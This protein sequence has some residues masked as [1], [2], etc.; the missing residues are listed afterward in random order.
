[1]H[2]S[3]CPQCQRY[4]A[5]ITE[6]TTA[7]EQ[8][9]RLN[10]QMKRV[11]DE[12][13]AKCAQKDIDLARKEG[14]MNAKLA[15]SV[16]DVERLTAEL[17]L[18]RGETGVLGSMNQSVQVVVSK[19]ASLEAHMMRLADDVRGLRPNDEQPP[20]A[21]A[22]FANSRLRSPG[23]RSLLVSIHNNKPAPPPPMAQSPTPDSP[24]TSERPRRLSID[25]DSSGSSSSSGG[26]VSSMTTCPPVVHIKKP[27]VSRTTSI[28]P[29]ETPGCSSQRLVGFKHCIDHNNSNSQQPTEQDRRG[30]SDGKSIGAERR[31]R[32]PAASRRTSLPIRRA[33]SSTLPKAHVPNDPD[34]MEY[35]EFDDLKDIVDPSSALT[36]AMTN[37]VRGGDYWREEFAALDDIRVLVKFHPDLILPELVPITNKMIEQLGNLRSSIVINCIMAFK[38]LLSCLGSAMD[39]CTKLVPVAIRKAVDKNNQFIVAEG[40]ALVDEI[41]RAMSG[42]KVCKEALPL[43]GDK[44]KN[45]RALAS[46]VIFMALDKFDANDVNDPAFNAEL[47]RAIA[48]GLTDSLTECRTDSK[49][50]LIVLR[51]KLEK[52]NPRVQAEWMKLVKNLEP[53]YALPVQQCLAS[54]PVDFDQ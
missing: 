24:N 34:K 10:A 38:A 27:L 48:P 33:A 6:L 26:T 15:Y 2:K 19:M 53:K 47:L 21:A 11:Y 9:S 1:M 14:E 37:L 20:A 8:T 16:K 12:M 44:D 28:I 30:R 5:K 45:I 4:E 49:N 42:K 52:A 29:C 43:M 18:A 39:K 31:C 25:S 35:K 36:R 13:V 32:S 50:S 17:A 51:Q 46:G 40:D 7:H 22:T 3:A 23:R 54:F 41:I